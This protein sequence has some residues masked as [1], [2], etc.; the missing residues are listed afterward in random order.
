M[1]TIVFLRSIPTCVGLTVPVPLSIR[2][3][4]VHPHVRGAHA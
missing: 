4:P 2:T 3:S 1:E